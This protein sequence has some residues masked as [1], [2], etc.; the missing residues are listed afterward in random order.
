MKTLS[1][2]CG[3][4]FDADL[5]DRIDLDAEPGRLAEILSG[6]FLTVECPHCGHRLKPDIPLRIVQNSRG[7]DLFYVPESDRADAM[8]GTLEYS[9]SDAPCFVIGYAELVERL[10]MEEL[11][12]DQR[13][14]EVLKFFLL[15]PALERAEGEEEGGDEGE[16][17][18]E[19]EAEIRI[20]FKERS[21]DWL[22]FHIS[23]I[24]EDEVAVSRLPVKTYGKVE[25]ELNRHLSGEPLSSFLS[26]PYVSINNIYWEDSE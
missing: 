23:G 13:V 17:E 16:K 9:V 14:I 25:S 10:I 11:G 4:S 8:R 5:P 3:E 26:P 2:N 21:D 24:K 7:L 12:L 20:L 18:E 1:C 19:G 15:Q 6:D 22:V